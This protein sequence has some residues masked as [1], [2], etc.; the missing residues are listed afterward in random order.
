MQGKGNPGDEMQMLR[1]LL[2]R[3]MVEQNEVRDQ[4]IM[5]FIE[6]FSTELSARLASL[7][8]Q[9]SRLAKEIDNRD[10]VVFDIGEGIASLG[11]QLRQL[12]SKAEAGEPAPAPRQAA[13]SAKA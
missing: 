5:E 8:A 1:G 9:V 4:K 12:A 7:E 6:Q 11:Q 2:L 10:N 3:P 13:K